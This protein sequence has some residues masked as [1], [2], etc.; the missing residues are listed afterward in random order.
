MGAYAYWILGLRVDYE[1]IEAL[2]KK[3]T[4]QLFERGCAHDIPKEDK[5]CKECGSP[6]MVKV[7]QPSIYPNEYG[8]S[9]FEKLGLKK[10]TIGDAQCIFVTTPGYLINL[11][12][13]MQGWVY[14]EIDISVLGNSEIEEVRK[15]LKEK[16]EPLGLWNEKKFKVWLAGQ[17]Y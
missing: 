7:K 9:L 11:G 3:E 5:F 4:V 13:I 10:I 12:N 15:E 8:E 6:N 17:Y 2:I 16:L 1:D 14:E